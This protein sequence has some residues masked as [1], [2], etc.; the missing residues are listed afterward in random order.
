MLIYDY[1]VWLR[2]GIGELDFLESTLFAA[3]P[4]NE[5]FSVSITEL[6]TVGVF[7]TNNFYWNSKFFS[8]ASSIKCSLLELKNTLSIW[9]NVLLK[10]LFYISLLSFSVFLDFYLKF[11]I[12]WAVLI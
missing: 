2:L 3:V 8:F 4:L 6:S 1:T 9:F 7:A 11:W 5:I 10:L 12:F